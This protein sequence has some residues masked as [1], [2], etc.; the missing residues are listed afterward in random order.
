M[1]ATTLI[2]CYTNIASNKVDLRVKKITRDVERQ[3]IMIT[4]SIQQGEQQS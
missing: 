4:V 3:N 2:R 1:L